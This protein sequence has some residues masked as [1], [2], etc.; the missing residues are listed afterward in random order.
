M[1]WIGRGDFDV[2]DWEQALE[3]AGSTVSRSFASY[4]VGT[5]ILGDLVKEG[6]TRLGY[7]GEAYGVDRL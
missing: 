1:L 5:P 2:A 6:S 3:Q 4:L 7:S